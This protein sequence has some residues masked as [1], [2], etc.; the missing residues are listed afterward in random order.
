MLTIS[1]SLGEIQN[2][3]L[4]LSE[5]IL[6]QRKK[7]Y[8][9]SA[10][11]DTILIYIKLTIRLLYLIEIKHTVFNKNEV[12]IRNENYKSKQVIISIKF[13]NSQICVFIKC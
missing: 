12:E 8:Y 7:N 3:V 13:K 10:K 6:R 5:L 1:S 2:F 9:S 11:F 4:E